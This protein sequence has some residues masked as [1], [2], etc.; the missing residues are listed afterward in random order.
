MTF[1][2]RPTER[3]DNKP[4]VIIT[5][6]KKGKDGKKGA[7]SLCPNILNRLWN[8]TIGLLL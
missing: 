4:T 5:E 7:M 3:R 2:P 8:K 6:K 1:G